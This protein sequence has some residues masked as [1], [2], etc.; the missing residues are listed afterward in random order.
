MGVDVKEFG[1]DDGD[2]EREAV[3]ARGCPSQILDETTEDIIIAP[4]ESTSKNHDAVVPETFQG[5]QNRV[6]SKEK[7]PSNS[8]KENTRQSRRYLEASSRKRVT[9]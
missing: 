1:P 8:W 5:S 6:V 3:L 9:R 2:E 4:A 7:H